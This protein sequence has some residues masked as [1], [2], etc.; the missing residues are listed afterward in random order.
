MPH[1]RDQGAKHGQS[2]ETS[3]GGF[4][5]R[6]RCGHAVGL[7]DHLLDDRQ[8]LVVVPVLPAFGL[9][10]LPGRGR[11]GEKL[12]ETLLLLALADVQPKLDDHRAAVGKLLLE[13]ANVIPGLQDLVLADGPFQVIFQHV[14]IP[15]AVEDGPV[16]RRRQLV[17][18]PPHPRM[19]SL[20]FVRRQNRM[21]LESA[22]IDGLGQ[23]IDDRPFARGVPTFEDD[24]NRH[25]GRAGLPLAFAQFPLQKRELLVVLFLG[26]RLIQ[27]DK[28]QHDVPPLKKRHRQRQPQDRSDTILIR[29]RARSKTPAIPFLGTE[30]SHLAR[31]SQKRW[32]CGFHRLQ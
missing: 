29:Q 28:F 23:A 30:H 17:P 31:D 26:N 19:E 24:D 13:L 22:G 14:A 27:I 20:G 4:H 25:A 2:G 18:E 3:L 11:A 6:P 21:D 12:L 7:H 15:G 8:P 32:T 9:A 1:R 10:D 5:E 16:A